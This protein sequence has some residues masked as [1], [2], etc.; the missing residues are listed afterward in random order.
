[1]ITDPA[2]GDLEEMKMRRALMV[3]AFLFVTAGVVT[4]AEAN[5]VRYMSKHPLPRK[6][7]HGFC[8]ID[9]PHFHD[10]PPSDPRMF[11][12]VDGQY[13][14]VGDP[15]PFDYDGERYSFYGPH[16]VVD[17]NVQLGGPTYCYLRGPHFHWYAPPPG[18][19]FEQKGGAY[20]YVGA[21]D[22]VYYNERPRYAVVNDAYAPIVY[23]RPVVDVTIAP[24]AF[25]GEIIA[26]GPGWRG[27]AVVGAPAVSAGVV[28]AAPPPPSLHVGVN[29][30]GPPVMIGGPPVVV[31]QRDVYVHEH[32]D[33]ERWEH[34]DNGRHE[35]WEHHDNGRH[36]GWRNGPPPGHAE[37]WRGGPAGPGPA[38]HGGGW[39]G[40]PPAAAPAPAAHAGGWRGGPAPQQAPHQNKP[41]WRR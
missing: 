29:I 33:H 12:Q 1:M 17:A 14:F 13:Y 22:P 21:Y 20:W 26:A 38:P 4:A 9:V 5:P 6:V 10:Y 40:G 30:G 8:Y 18:A 35:G 36:E 11:R 25:R 31:E 28:I 37:G 41:G 23:T 3:S 34:H 27:Q 2:G 19:Q 16:P 15:A 39:R 32:R 7:G 24:P